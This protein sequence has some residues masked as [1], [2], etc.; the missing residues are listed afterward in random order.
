MNVFTLEDTLVLNK[1]KFFIAKPDSKGRMLIPPPIRKN[2]G[3]KFRAPVLLGFESRSNLVFLKRRVDGKG[4]VYV[5]TIP[6]GC[7]VSVEILNEGEDE[8][9]RK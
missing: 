6:E 3:I 2:L 9:D 7:L 1:V 4:R 5:S 8:D